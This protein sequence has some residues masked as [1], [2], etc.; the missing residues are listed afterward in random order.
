MEVNRL[1]VTYQRNMLIG[2]MVAVVL[3]VISAALVVS[4][5]SP[6]KVRV[7]YPNGTSQMMPRGEPYDRPMGVAPLTLLHHSDTTHLPFFASFRIIRDGEVSP[8]HDFHYSVFDDRETMCYKPSIDEAS[9]PGI[10]VNDGE[11][12]GFPA[13]SY[14]DEWFPGERR[15]PSFNQEAKLLMDVEPEYPLVAR[16][17]WIEGEVTVLVFVDARGELRPFPVTTAE[18]NR[19]IDTFFVVRETPSGWY[20]SDAVKEVLPQWKFLPRIEDGTPVQSFMKIT[21]HFC[22]GISCTK[23]HI[24]TILRDSL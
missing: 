4:S 19:Y 10:G 7:G 9:W 14:G 23:L 22:L 12:S 18:G 6:D 13:G 5:E 3:A 15:P 11:G 1:K 17:E 24:Q 20:F 21:Y 8:L 2:Q 16:S